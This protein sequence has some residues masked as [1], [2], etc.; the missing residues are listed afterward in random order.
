M[1]ASLVNQSTENI[2]NGVSVDKL[3]EITG[4]IKNNSDI[5]KFNFRAKG[6]WISGAHTQT[7]VK[8]FYGE[9][10]QKIEKKHLYWKRMNHLL[11]LAT[12]SA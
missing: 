1:I 11:L 5:A 3:F 2:V 6:K 10:E 4:V 8:D 9:V 7:I 12:N